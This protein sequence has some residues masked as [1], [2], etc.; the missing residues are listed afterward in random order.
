M[1]TS[2]PTIDDPIDRAEFFLALSRNDEDLVAY[3]NSA[4]QLSYLVNS[5][6]LADEVLAS[7]SFRPPSHPYRSLSNH[8]TSA[9]TFLLKLRKR[10][11][12]NTNV[13][14]QIQTTW[15]RSFPWLRSELAKHATAGQAIDFGQAA[16][17][18]VSRVTAKLLFGKDIGLASGQFV[19]ASDLIEE[20]FVNRGGQP[21]SAEPVLL[22]AVLDDCEA[23]MD[24]L[25]LTFV[26]GYRGVA[27]EVLAR[28]AVR[29]LLNGYNAM[30][31]SLSWTMFL[32]ACNPGI[33][34][35]IHR[36]IS[37]STAAG[38]LSQAKQLGT[39]EMTRT[40]IMESLRLFPPAWLIGRVAQREVEVGDYKFGKGD[41][42]VISPYAMHRKPN[43]WE[44]PTKF[45]PERFENRGKHIAGFYPFGGG[46]NKC[47]A[48][49]FIVPQL[50]TMVGLLL[51]SFSF[52]P[53]SEA[54]RPRGLVS[55]R[56]TPWICLYVKELDQ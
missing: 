40:A 51:T 53:T 37:S 44:A 47:P 33:Q 17:R 3:R 9:G 29:T 38:A 13:P 39:C 6:Y 48:S 27:T 5:H 4:G 10:I 25:G 41:D 52:S 50:Q 18:W 8:L 2:W 54:I 36:K 42:V 7:D 19:K 49:H 23:F 30:A 26:S 28:T 34:S 45:R 31:T 21:R 1:H 43:L 55:L 16:K 32:L 20:S 11:E 12:S 15:I 22:K 35:S 24:Q 14:D 46:S 56:P